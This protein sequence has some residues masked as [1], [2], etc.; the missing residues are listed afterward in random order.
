MLARI[1]PGE[2]EKGNAMPHADL[3]QIVPFRDLSEHGRRLVAHGATL[4]RFPAGKTIVERG[5]DVSGAYFVVDGRLRVFSL[6]PAGREATLYH[7]DP[8]GTCVFALNSL[9]NDLL[10][11]AWVQTERPSIV[12]IIPGPLY[13]AL[14]HAET[15]IRDLTVRT[16]STLV[17]RLMAELDEVHSCTL[18][19]RLAGFLLVHADGRGV[20]R[21]TQQEIADQIG[22]T[23]EVVARLTSRLVQAGWIATARGAVTLRDRPRLAALSGRQPPP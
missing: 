3:S 8:G 10:Y 13:R 9:F 1:T 6:L 2:G 15:T 18:E 7:I 21:L 14:F 23:R 19:Q 4:H 17:F 11:P 5:Q 22:T 20:L 12:A 16:L